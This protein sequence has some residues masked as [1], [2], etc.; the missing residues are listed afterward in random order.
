MPELSVRRATPADVT[1][2]RALTRRAYAKWVPVVGREPRPMTVDYE[3][4]VS[5][6]LID[7]L[8]EHGDAIGLIELQV[9]TDHL[10]IVNIAVAPERHGQGIGTRLL[11]HAETVARQHGLGEIRLYTNGLMISNI[12]L[13]QRRGYREDCREEAGPLGVAVYMSKRLDPIRS[14]EP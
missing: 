7:I 2:V 6:H 14:V 10:L 4:A 12:G 5:Q 13:Y 3:H 9:A 8:E 11:G 1:L